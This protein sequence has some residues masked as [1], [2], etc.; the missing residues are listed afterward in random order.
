[1]K[2]LEESFCLDKIDK[3]WKDFF[4]NEFKREELIEIL[5]KVDSDS[6]KNNCYP[7]NKD[8]FR[9]FRE[10][11]LENIKVI[12]IGQDPYYQPGIADGFAF[13]TRKEN[14]IPASLGNIFKELNED[15]NCNHKR[16]NCDLTNWVKQ[17]VFLLNTSLT[18][19]ESQQKSHSELWREFTFELSKYINKNRKD[20]IWVF[21]GRDAKS[22]RD[23]CKINPEMSISGSHP[24]PFSASFGF[25]GSKPFSK[26]NHKLSLL[27]KTKINWC[28]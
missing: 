19:R 13:S 18:V 28:V 8:V 14:F 23:N 12:I 1:M 11:S 9:L 3:S 5:K 7:K 2:N 21:W 22:L 4:F 10:L 15:I 17:G 20:I 27:K 16:E 25:F 6:K 26:I 24:S